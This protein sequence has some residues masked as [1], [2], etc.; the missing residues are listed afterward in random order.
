MDSL[1]SLAGAP[2]PEGGYYSDVAR[3]LAGF[4]H[5]LKEVANFPEMLRLLEVQARE[6]NALRGEIHCL[7]HLSRTGHDGWLDARAAAGHMGISP[8]C[9]DKYRYNTNPKIKGYKL[10]GK[11]LYKKSDLDNF[12]R[13]YATKSRELP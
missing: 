8:G 13:L 11:V 3:D 5:W 10:D 7:R 6:I 1:G 4:G 12:V 2:V 9:F